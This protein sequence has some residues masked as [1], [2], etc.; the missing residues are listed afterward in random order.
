MVEE[1]ACRSWA[2]GRK[3]RRAGGA[4]D[5]LPVPGG[6]LGDGESI[7]GTDNGDG[8]DASVEPTRFDSVMLP[9][10]M[11]ND[12]VIGGIEVV[13]M[14]G[15]AAGPQVNLDAAGAKLTSVEEDERVAKIGP[16]TVT[17]RP[18]VNDLQRIAVSRGKARRYR[19]RMPSGA[20]RDLGN[21]G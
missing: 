9:D 1:V 6:E 4:A 12:R 19:S 10:E 20:E 5:T 3:T 18:T 17:P 2:A 7:D 14:I 11:E 8:N 21:L 16:E 13:P 15:P